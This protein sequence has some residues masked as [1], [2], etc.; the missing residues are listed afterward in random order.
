LGA[1]RDLRAGATLA[2]VR[3]RPAAGARGRLVIGRFRPVLVVITVVV[4]VVLMMLLLLLLLLVVVVVMLE[5]L[6]EQRVREQ[7]ADDGLPVSGRWRR[8]RLRE[9]AAAGRLVFLGPRSDDFRRVFGARGG[10]DDGGGGGG[11]AGG[12]RRFA[13]CRGRFVAEYVG[14]AE[15]LDPAGHGLRAVG[16][17]RRRRPVRGYGPATVRRRAGGGVGGRRR[18]GNGGGGG[19][20]GRH[21]VDVV[22]PLLPVRGPPFGRVVFPVA[23]AVAHLVDGHRAQLL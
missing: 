8:R 19:G 15:R 6:Y 21:R 11:R 3:A 22:R 1:A 16:R 13:A 5:V 20:D 17:G 12:R 2:A 14:D 18:G 7:G 23:N 10:D 9:R 4:T